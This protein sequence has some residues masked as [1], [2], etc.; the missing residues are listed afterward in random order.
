MNND[1]NKIEVILAEFKQDY[2]LTILNST[3]IKESDFYIVEVMSELTNQTK[4]LII[5]TNKEGF[6]VE[7]TLMRKFTI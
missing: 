6:N 5:H 7:H 2:K 4:N 1:K 3:Y